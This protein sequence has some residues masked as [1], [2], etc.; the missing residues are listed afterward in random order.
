MEGLSVQQHMRKLIESGSREEFGSKRHWPLNGIYWHRVVYDEIHEIEFRS[1]ACKSRIES[2]RGSWYWG[3]TGTPAKGSSYALSNM[4]Q[5]LNCRSME[6]RS[7]D[8]LEKVIKRNV[9]NLALPALSLEE[10]FITLT[11]SERALLS[12]LSSETNEHVKT[13][14][15]MCSHHQISSQI[16]NVTGASTSNPLSS[17]QVS[18]AVQSSRLVRISDTERDISEAIKAL[19]NFM[20]RVKRG[21]FDQEPDEIQVKAESNSNDDEVVK[22]KAEPNDG[23][24]KDTMVSPRYI[25]DKYNPTSHPFW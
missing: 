22:V 21:D 24:K 7:T 6:L 20:E 9:P 8:L 19:D 13:V 18:K 12:S 1:K 16:V 2:I 10:V 14:L 25:Y 17:E 3:L 23:K 15:Q 4:C 5:W 11:N